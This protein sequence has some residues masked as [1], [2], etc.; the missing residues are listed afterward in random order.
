MCFCWIV[1]PKM[2]VSAGA[3]TA[4]VGAVV[5]MM[6]SIHHAAI[7]DA[8]PLETFLSHSEPDAVIVPASFD[9]SMHKG[10]RHLCRGKQDRLCSACSNR[11]TAQPVLAGEADS[12]GEAE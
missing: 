10:E 4:A 3:A 2:R 1:I 11:T 8:S 7:S 6:T 12:T 5:V 9:Y